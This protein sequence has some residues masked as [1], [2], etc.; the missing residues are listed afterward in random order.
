MET[1][2]QG[3]EKKKPFLSHISTKLP[4]V[5][6]IVV[7]MA[8]LVLIL[9]TAGAVMLNLSP[10]TVTVVPPQSSDD[11]QI[12]F[13]K[14]EDPNAC[15]IS[16]EERY[17]N[18]TKLNISNKKITLSADE[19]SKFK[20]KFKNL[21]PASFY[22]IPGELKRYVFNKEQDKVAYILETIDKDGKK[23]RAVHLYDFNKKTNKIVY[24]Y[25]SVPTDDPDYTYE[26]KDL[27]FSP[28][29]TLLAI[30]TTTGSLLH[31]FSEESTVELFDYTEREKN[32]TRRWLYAFASP[33]ISQNNKYL[34]YTEGYYEGANNF[35]YNLETGVTTDPG[36]TAYVAGS[37]AFGWY[38]NKMLVQKMDYGWSQEPIENE[39]NNGI[40]LVSPE[41]LTDIIFLLDNKTEM[42]YGVGPIIG[43]Y[44]Y[45]KSNERA[46]SDK[47]S[48]NNVG[49]KL[50]VESTFDILRVFNIDTRQ[51]KE[52]LRTDTTN[53]SGVA[54]SPV[55]F[56]TDSLVI[57]GREEVIVA[58]AR[59]VNFDFSEFYVLNDDNTLSPITNVAAN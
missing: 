10:Q 53:F 4:I 54:D 27:G 42:F 23:T 52:V 50:Q 6:L 37:N 2:I 46:L 59:N 32:K 5:M 48:C 28:D 47:F 7:M 11:E 43:D 41:K 16:P 8:T 1:E 9:L 51:S 30:T 29:S 26:L 34:L 56:I 49:S 40:L 17:S 24:E 25:E 19:L 38:D 22:K 20:I 3:D 57:G 55:Y 45:I 14:P 33:R 21:N 15:W 31:K 12:S 18:F 44:L 36:Y 58:I 13:P 39:P 35:I